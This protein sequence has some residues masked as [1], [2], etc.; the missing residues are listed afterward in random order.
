MSTDD[1]II[2][3]HRA[4]EFAFQADLSP[5]SRNFTLEAAQRILPKAS[6]PEIAKIIHSIAMQESRRTT[7]DHGKLQ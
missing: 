2:A 6:R 5:E 3:P 1:D 7:S 4:L